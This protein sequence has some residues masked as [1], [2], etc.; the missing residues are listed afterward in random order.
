MNIFKYFKIK[1]KIKSVKIKVLTDLPI[2]Q[3]IN[4]A[5]Y[6]INI[7]THQNQK[8]INVSFQIQEGL[9]LYAQCY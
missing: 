3:K 9:K 4:S 7:D 8:I 2:F 6:G 5:K 1:P